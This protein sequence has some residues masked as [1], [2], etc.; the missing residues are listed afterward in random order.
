MKIFGSQDFPLQPV[1]VVLPVSQKVT[2]SPPIRV[3][4][5]P[6]QNFYIQQIFTLLLLEVGD[7]RIKTKNGYKNFQQQNKS[8]FLRNLYKIFCGVCTFLQELVIHHHEGLLQ[9][10]RF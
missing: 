7:E 2:K 4:T 5:T 1:G 9:A 10:E 3:P 6:T 8:I